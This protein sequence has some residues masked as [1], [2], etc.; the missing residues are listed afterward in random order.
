MKLAG[1]QAN[2][3]FAKPETNRSG[4]LI[5]GADAMRVALKRQQVIAA[6]IGPAGEAET[7]LTRIAAGELRKDPAM[8]NDAIKAQSF[9]PGP[10]V[11]F[12]EDAADGLTK[13]IT[14]A[15]KDWSDG[16]A[17]IIVTANQLRASSS[18]RKLFE[19]HPNAYAAGIYDDPPTRDEIEAELR[20]AGLRD[21]PRDALEALGALARMIPPG[22]FRQTIEKISLYKL[23]DD[24]SLSTDEIDLCAPLSQETGIDDVLNC[25]AEGR[26]EEIG[27]VMQRLRSQGIQPVSLCIN[28]TR[29]F[30]LLYTAASDP[31]GVSAGIGKLRPPVYGPRR[32]RLQR[33]AT[34]WGAQRA[35]RALCMLTDVDLQLRSANQNSPAMAVVERALVRL[36]MFA[37]R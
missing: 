24:S 25:V 8:L 9:F 3:Y 17:Q 5:Y 34:S 20:T 7:R 18:L 33:Q 13:I 31:G 29:H 36:A 11:A 37:Q 15:L 1:R 23:G 27:P 19:K 4:L 6:L 22:D 32:D 2:G 12:V 35:K 28:A 14:A 10:M 26:K 21:L 30:K 16:D